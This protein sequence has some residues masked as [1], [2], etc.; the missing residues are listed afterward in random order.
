MEMLVNFDVE[1]FALSYRQ[2]SELS[3]R[4]HPKDPAE[5]VVFKSYG[6]QLDD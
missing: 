1:I 2:K 4:P 5:T 3:N 6:G